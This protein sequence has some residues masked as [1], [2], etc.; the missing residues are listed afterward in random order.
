VSKDALGNLEITISSFST[1][2][3]NSKRKQYRYWLKE[4]L[5]EV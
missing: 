2:A 4:K 1:S 3:H 5:R